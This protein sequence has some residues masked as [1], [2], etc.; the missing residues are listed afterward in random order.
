[1]TR[2]GGAAAGTPSFAGVAVPFGQLPNAV[3][4]SFLSSG[5]VIAPVTTSAALPGTKCCRQNACR[6]SR[7]SCLFDS[8]VPISLNPY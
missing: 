8:G 5:T 1:M 2:R 4:A 3:S 6:S 7:V